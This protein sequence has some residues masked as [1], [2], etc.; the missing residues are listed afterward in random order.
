MTDNNEIQRAVREYILE[1]FLTAADAQRFRDDDDL[2]LLLDSLQILRLLISLE[3][4]FG[5]KIEDGDLTPENIGS[6]KK[7]TATI[8]RKR[9]VASA[10]QSGAEEKMASGVA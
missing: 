4:K 3:G 7:L 6:V 8:E 1:S 10:A 5:V 2:L 9:G